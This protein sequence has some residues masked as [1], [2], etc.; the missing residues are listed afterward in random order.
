[1]WSAFSPACGRRVELHH[2]QG[3]FSKPSESW[4]RRSRRVV[5]QSSISTV[6]KTDFIGTRRRGKKDLSEFCGS[7]FRS[8][9]RRNPSGNSGELGGARITT[10]IGFP[11]SLS[12]T[13]LLV[14]RDGRKDRRSG[15]LGEM[16]AFNQP[17]NQPANQPVRTL[18]D[19]VGFEIG[20]DILCMYILRYR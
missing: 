20:R 18:R 1:M 17:T 15:V 11:N 12:T 19:R 10:N 3:T 8:L 14:C 5:T 4:R 7:E 6:L 16:H 2:L 9:D 13:R